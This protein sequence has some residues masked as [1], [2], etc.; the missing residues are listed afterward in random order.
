MDA[1]GVTAQHHRR[2]W[3]GFDV[4]HGVPPVQ[5]RHA[6]NNRRKEYKLTSWC[7]TLPTAPFT[8]VRRSGRRPRE[9]NDGR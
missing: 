3:M 2:R 6:A 4:L 9:R 8:A 1:A 5:P 7:A